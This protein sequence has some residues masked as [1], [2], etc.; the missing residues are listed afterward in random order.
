MPS[1][2]ERRKLSRN[3]YNLKHVVSFVYLCVFHVLGRHQMASLTMEYQYDERCAI[4][5]KTNAN[6]LSVPDERVCEE[7]KY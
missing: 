1:C 7:C 5:E 2:R 6:I 3:K 4:E